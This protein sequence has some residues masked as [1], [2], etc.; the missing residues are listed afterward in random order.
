MPN[1]F[2]DLLTFDCWYC[3]LFHENME[4]GRVGLV[5]NDMIQVQ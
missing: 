3:D 5:I 2:H 4:A 1:R